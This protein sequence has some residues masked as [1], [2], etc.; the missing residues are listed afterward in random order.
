MLPDINER[1]LRMEV[2]ML[3]LVNVLFIFDEFFALLIWVEGR[4]TAISGLPDVGLYTNYFSYA[5][6]L[7]PI[8]ELSFAVISYWS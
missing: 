4:L 6:I 7:D 8:D 5:V 3:R 2:L 1:L